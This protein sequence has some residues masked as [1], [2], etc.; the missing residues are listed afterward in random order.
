MCLLQRWRK[1]A[2]ANRSSDQKPAPPI[3]SSLA[4]S[5]FKTDVNRNKT[6]KWI[7]AKSA[8]Y[9]G[10]DWGEYDQEDEYGVEQTPPPLPGQANVLQHKPSFEKGDERRVFSTGS[11]PPTQHVP[12]NMGRVVSTASAAPTETSEV[13]SI[14]PQHR[15]DY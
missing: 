6:R 5:S 14:N 7:E 12:D 2:T 13:S 8:S 9:G 4:P 11:Q 10:D 3:S 15:R 1:E